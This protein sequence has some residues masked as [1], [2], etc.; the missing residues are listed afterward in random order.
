MSS[1]L[2]STLLPSSSSRDISGLMTN[3]NLILKNSPTRL[4]VVYRSPTLFLFFLSPYLIKYSNS[5]FPIFSKLTISSIKSPKSINLPPST[6]S[7]TALLW[8]RL[9]LL[10]VQVWQIMRCRLW[11]LAVWC[12]FRVST[13]LSWL[14]WRQLLAFGQ[15]WG[16]HSSM[17]MRW[18]RKMILRRS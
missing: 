17:K 11:R 18:R 7:D 3:S 2:Y 8:P 14:S 16:T 4:A 1:L 13:W 15:L 9:L 5:F 12:L 10:L 6:T